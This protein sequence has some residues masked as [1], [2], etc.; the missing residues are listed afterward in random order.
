VFSQADASHGFWGIPIR[1]AD[2]EKT[3]FLT[4]NGLYYYN[5][6][7]MGLKG[8]PATYAR[9]GDL[10]FGHLFF[11]D[12]S[13]LPSL[14]GYL[15]ELATTF[16]LYV[17]DHNTASET[18]EDHFDFLW[19]Y[20][21]PRIAWAPISLNGKKT[22]LF[23]SSMES[24]GFTVDENGIRPAQKHRE[25][26]AQLKKHFQENPPRSWEEVQPLLHLTP[27]VRKFIPGRAELIQRIKHAFFEYSSTVTKSG[28]PSVLRRETKRDTPEWNTGAA[29]A[30]EKICDAIQNNATSGADSEKQ[31]HLATDASE[32]GTG[33]VL[34]Q[35]DGVP[36]GE[37]IDEKNFKNARIIMWI[38][39]RFNDAERRYTMPEKEML[40]VVRGLNESDWMINH[41]SHPVKVYTDHK[42][43]TD[44]MANRGHLHGK[45][46]RWIEILGEYDIEYRHRSCTDKV[47]RLADGMSRLPEAQKEDAK[48]VELR[49]GIERILGITPP[50]ELSA[51]TILPGGRAPGKRLITNSG[52][53]DIGHW[54]HESWYSE[55]ISTLLR[56]LSSVGEGRRRLMKRRVLRYRI[57]DNALHY[58][59]NDES[60][61]LCATESEVPIILQ[62]AH[63]R[64]GH[65][66]VAIT[67]ERLRGR[68]WWPSRA[69][70]IEN[71]CRSCMVCQQTA[72]RVP[73]SLSGSITKLAPWDMVGMDYI[74]PINPPS[75]E[76]HQY[77]LVIADYMTK[78]VGLA[79][80]TTADGEHVFETWESQWAAMFGWPKVIYCD[81]GSHFVNMKVKMAAERHGTRMELGP[82]SHPSSTGLPERVVRLVKNQL[83]KWA[84]EREGLALNLWHLA[85]PTIN[86]NLN[87]RYIEGIGTSPA[88][89][90]LGWEPFSKHPGILEQLPDEQT[91]S[92]NE[93]VAR[94]LNLA[95]VDTREELREN[96]QNRV[97]NLTQPAVPRT[98]R[99]L[100]VGTVVW[101]K[102]DKAGTLKTKFHK[103]WGNLSRV[104]E[105][106]SEV[107]YMTTSL[108]A[109]G[110]ARK[111]HVDD[112]KPYVRRLAR[113]EPPKI[114]GLEL[115]SDKEDQRQ[116]LEDPTWDNPEIV[117]PYANM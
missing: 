98:H 59:E 87:N 35:L 37:D 112:L 39:G 44:S 75:T 69:S 43:I 101:E 62:N 30:L 17:D 95:L 97:N 110:K 85:V 64:C 48:P 32:N 102:Q 41:S 57:F 93:H 29:T 13:E 82:T 5:N 40:A 22:S 106:V 54:E 67:S 89:A 78:F 52:K 114:A 28:K 105:Q 73:A 49:L 94:E 108:V 99:R 58:L 7:P 83:Q 47:M 104:T 116:M 103:S 86:V 21:F 88:M 45:V 117:D 42:G 76:G 66:A 81:N 92:D 50:M 11:D 53:P 3:G 20:Y 115:N 36:A 25:K 19:K 12:G 65:F 56:G 107:T 113:L 18:F 16:F 63:D 26:F 60:W 8:S 71:Y 111:V 77:I 6:T 80:H 33:G 51:N 31:F 61:A 74:G 1:P 46:S 84:A 68:H 14:Q 23:M 9:F 79:C 90:M 100:R 34:L 109:P 70:D 27:F 72:P 91:L 96:I 15:K 24:L 10:V 2:R 4:P 38:S 55:I